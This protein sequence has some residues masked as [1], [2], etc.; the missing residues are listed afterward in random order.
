VGLLCVC[1]VMCVGSGL[2]TGLSPRPSRR[3]DCVQDQETEKI[4][5]GPTKG[6]RAIIV[7]NYTH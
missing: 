6:C 2:A 1:V 4:G 5:Q 7:N 3:T